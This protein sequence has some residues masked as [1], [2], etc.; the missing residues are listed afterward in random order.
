MGR[1]QL[2]T[3]AFMQS[4]AISATRLPRS[5]VAVAPAAATPHLVATLAYSSATLHPVEIVF[6]PNYF[7]FTP[8][9]LRTTESG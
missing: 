3:L 7:D 6:N 2:V 9:V 1:G 8:V 4:F 5:R